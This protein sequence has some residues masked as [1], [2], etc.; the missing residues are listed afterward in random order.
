ML[1]F[2]HPMLHI[3][4]KSTLYDTTKHHNILPLH[5]KLKHLF[6]ARCDVRCEGGVCGH[7]GRWRGRSKIHSPHRTLHHQAARAE[8]FEDWPRQAGDQL[9]EVTNSFCQV[10]Q[11]L[12]P[13]KNKKQS[14]IFRV[15]KVKYKSVEE[16]SKAEE[17]LIPYQHDS[18]SPTCSAIL[19][20]SCNV[21]G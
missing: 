3:T 2:Y 21:G 19:S 15:Y 7:P 4:I 14:K 12:H 9:D 13:H 16:G 20:V 18:E 10:N 6:R 5:V 11:N 17:K 1:W 8:Q